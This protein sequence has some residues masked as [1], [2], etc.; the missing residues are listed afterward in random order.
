MPH[1][2]DG[3]RVLLAEPDDAVRDVLTFSLEDAGFLV[4][5]VRS[6]VEA[7]AALASGGRTGFRAVLVATDL[8]PDEQAGWAFAANASRAQPGLGLVYLAGEGREAW[9]HAAMR[10]GV[11]LQKPF[12][13][14]E[15]LEAL[16]TVLGST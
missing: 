16:D 15:L 14:R 4:T 7:E 3:C 11:L 6:H 13:R 12:S 5:P 10:G 8:G 1:R 2:S 9:Q